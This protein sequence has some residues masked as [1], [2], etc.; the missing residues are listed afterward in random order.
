M[1]TTVQDVIEATNRANEAREAYGRQEQAR[2]RAIFS[3]PKRDEHEQPLPPPTET[4]KARDAEIAALE[5]TIAAHG[6][7]HGQVWPEVEL[8][9]RRV[10]RLRREQEE[11][12]ALRVIARH[13]ARLAAIAA[14]RPKPP[15]VVKA[16]TAPSAA[17]DRYVL[18]HGVEPRDVVVNGRIIAFRWPISV[19]SRDEW[20]AVANALAEDERRLARQRSGGEPR[21]IDLARER[22]MLPLDGRPTSA[23]ALLAL[24]K[25]HDGRRG[26]AP[27]IGDAEWLVHVQDLIDS[28]PTFG[29]ERSASTDDA[30]E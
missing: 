19:F 1:T 27:A 16:S 17:D 18:H 10:A 9:R 12:V 28:W 13:D 14:A 7:G 22:F 2:L 24:R 11:D 6:A 20:P 30:A 26:M 25:R 5:Q 3:S 15:P 4:E 23:E 8:L 21:E 29:S